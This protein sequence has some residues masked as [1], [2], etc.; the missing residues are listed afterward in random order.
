MIASA[1][2]D[3]ARC[4]SASITEGVSADQPMGPAKQNVAARNSGQWK[5][6]EKIVGEATLRRTNRI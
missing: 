3:S 5:T 4:P 2:P 1:S 6:E